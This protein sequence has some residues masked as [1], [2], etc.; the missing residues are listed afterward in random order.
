M[1]L[2]IPDDIMQ[3]SGLTEEDCLIEL[4]VR[5][6][7]DRR[8]SLAQALRLAGLDRFAFERQL[9]WRNISLYTVD[10]LHED[11]ATLKDLGR[12]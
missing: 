10:D 11:V 8:L 4:S 3:S 1:K 5:L 6:Y 7:A 9:A 12:R 2:D